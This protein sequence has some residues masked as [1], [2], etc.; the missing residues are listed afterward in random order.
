MLFSLLKSDALLGRFAHWD[1]FRGVETPGLNP[2]SLRDKVHSAEDR[3]PSGQGS[4]V[5]ALARSAQKLTCPVPFLAFSIVLLFSI[6]AFGQE[7]VTFAHYN[8]ENYLEQDRREGSDIV[9]APKPESEKNTVVRIISEIHPDILGVA[10]MGPED[11][12]REFQNRLEKIGL[13]LPFTEYVSGPDPDRHLALLSRFEIVARH[14]ENVV[15]YDLNGQRSQ[16]LRGFLDVTL[17]VNQAYRLRV[18]GAHLKSKLPNL[19]GEA[20]LRRNEA[21]LLRRHID[22]VLDRDGDANLL[23]YGDMNDTKDQPAIQEIV[24]SRRRANRL[25]ELPL[26]DEQGDYWTYYRRQSDTYDRIDYIIVNGVLSPQ[27]DQRLSHIY[28]S[29][30]WYSAS[31]HR[32]IVAVIKVNAR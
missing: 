28:R 10:E 20:L 31:D 4:G 7:T 32:P 25:V 2:L 22:E 18:I 3:V 14:S 19:S 15:E 27:I 29:K 24:G 26:T 1:V 9:L 17:Q 6:A 8:I 30:D 11:Q 16:V 5:S 23:V 13:H 12:F 21:C